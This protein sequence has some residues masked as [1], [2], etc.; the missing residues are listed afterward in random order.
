M[1]IGRVGKGREY[2]GREKERG[3]EREGRGREEEAEAASSE[4]GRKRK[5]RLACLCRGGRVGIG[6]I[7]L[8][9]GQGTPATVQASII[10]TVTPP[11]VRLFEFIST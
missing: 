1:G 6:R 10:I 9:K 4:E 5:R 2:G 7:C 8:L 3:A 11:Q